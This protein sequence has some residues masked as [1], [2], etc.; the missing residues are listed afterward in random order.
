MKNLEPYINCTLEIFDEEGKSLDKLGGSGDQ[1]FSFLHP[2]APQTFAILPVSIEE[3][4]KIQERSHLLKVQRKPITG[5]INELISETDELC[6]L[7]P[8]T[9]EEARL[10]ARKLNC[11]YMYWSAWDLERMLIV[12]DTYY[13]GPVWEDPSLVYYYAGID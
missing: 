4:L 9:V 8:E 5:E 7:F 10:I 2:D 11:D 1:F 3:V 13:D 12:T 6:M